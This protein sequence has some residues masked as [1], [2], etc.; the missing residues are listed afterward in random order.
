MNSFFKDNIHPATYAM[1]RNINNDI[2][3]TIGKIQSIYNAY[4]NRSL[5]MNLVTILF[6]EIDNE[7]YNR[8]LL[9]TMDISKP[10][11]FRDTG[12]PCSQTNSYLEAIKYDKSDPEFQSHLYGFNI[13]LTCINSH[14]DQLYYSGGFITRSKIIFII[15]ML[16]HESIHL[17]EYAD[18]M[19]MNATNNHTPFFYLFA[20]NLYSGISRLSENIDMRHLSFGIKDRIENIHKMHTHYVL[21]DGEDILND[22][23]HYINNRGREVLIGYIAYPIFK[24]GRKIIPLESINISSNTQI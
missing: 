7:F 4:K 13:S 5:D 11:L 19:L 3:T 1:I 22:H 16:L 9:G 20:N 17:I 21:N 12:L 8:N 18:P 6:N 24:E 14:N 15:L 10:I 23:S 2:P